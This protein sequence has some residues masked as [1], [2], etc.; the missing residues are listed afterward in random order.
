L[1]ERLLHLDP[2]L[3][4]LLMESG[5]GVSGTLPRLVQRMR[6]RGQ[7][8]EMA[9][10]PGDSLQDLQTTEQQDQ[11]IRTLTEWFDGSFPAAAAPVPARVAG[12]GPAP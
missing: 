1:T 6:R 4:V 2:A 5:S 12:G 3:R 8:V 10:L 11:V 7:T 9:P